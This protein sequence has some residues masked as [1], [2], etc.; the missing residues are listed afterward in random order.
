MAERHNEF[1]TRIAIVTPENIAFDHRVA[2]PFQRLPAYLLDLIFRVVVFILLCVVAALTFGLEFAFAWGLVSYFAL[3][4]F[5]GG[6]FETVWNGQTP[7]KRMM[8]L[9]VVTVH[10]EPI[11]ATQA[12]L[13][14]LFRILDGFPPAV[15]MIPIAGG[16]LGE[17]PLVFMSFQL[18]IFASMMNA[19]YQ[20]LGD[21]VAGTIVVAE[22]QEG[23]YGVLR[24]MEPE[25]IR[26]AAD[27]PLHFDV[28]RSMGLALSS[29]VQ[30]R[31]M[32]GW[33]RREEIARHLAEPLRQRLG[34]AFIPSYDLLLRALYYKAFVEER[35]GGTP[36]AAPGLPTA[37]PSAAWG[38]WMPPPPG[39]AQPGYPPSGYPSPGSPV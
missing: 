5:Y 28:P 14:N 9:R 6:F 26:L 22:E 32:F 16:A 36:T 37:G 34:L 15:L 38:P 2:G 31:V 12:V 21:L 4:V 17:I 24:V 25:A 30:R 8:R 13:R 33:A 19:R 27:L 29:Y 11:D 1:D 39:M 20:R 35:P 7:G 18:A 10:G 3:D 23:M